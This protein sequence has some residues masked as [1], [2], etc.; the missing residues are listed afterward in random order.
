MKTEE[1][2]QGKD[3]SIYMVFEYLEHDLNGLLQFY[4]KQFTEAQ[5]KGYVK[6]LLAGLGHC[7]KNMIIH[8][9]IKGFFFVFFFPTR[10][11]I[12]SFINV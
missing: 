3:V 7:H 5:I 9:D 2:E 4:G 6:Q 10:E 8:R 11:R 1:F 12:R